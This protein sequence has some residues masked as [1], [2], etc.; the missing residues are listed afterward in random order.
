V[1]DEKRYT[2]TTSHHTLHISYKCLTKR[3]MQLQCIPINI[4]Q[5]GTYNFKVENMLRQ[6]RCNETICNDVVIIPDGF[7]LIGHNKSSS[8]G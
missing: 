2:I 1:L 6:Q 4:L 8:P 3:D 7:D 5:A